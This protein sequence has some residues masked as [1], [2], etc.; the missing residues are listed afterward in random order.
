MS[1]TVRLFAYDGVI[2]M[3]IGSDNGHLAQHS[4]FMFKER[5]KAR[6]TLT[7]DTGTPQT[8]AAALS[9]HAGIRLLR[10]QVESGKR[11]HY[12]MTPSGYDAQIADTSSPIISEDE[13]LQ[14]G[15]GWTI[16]LLEAS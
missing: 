11:V 5:Y 6:Q 13:T 1:A 4:G 2:V 14:F 15:T 8:T 10:V 3:P 16:S 12:E 9:T 7:V